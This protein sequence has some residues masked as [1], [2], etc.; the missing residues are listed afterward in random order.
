[1]VNQDKGQPIGARNDQLTVLTNALEVILQLVNTMQT[2]SDYTNNNMRHHIDPA[3]SNHSGELSQHCTSIS[4]STP[5]PSLLQQSTRIAHRVAYKDLQ[6]I[7]PPK[8]DLLESDVS[9]IEDW[10]DSSEGEGV[11]EAANMLDELCQQPAVNEQTT[12]NISTPN[13]STQIIE[14]TCNPTLV[15]GNVGIKVVLPRVQ[16]PSPTRVSKIHTEPTPDSTKH[17]STHKAAKEK[18]L[19][20]TTLRNIE[21]AVVQGQCKICDLQANELRRTKLHARQ[22][23]TLHMCKCKLFSP[24]RDTI[25]RHQRQG[26]CPLQQ[27]DIY[28]VDKESYPAFCQHIGW[29]DPPKFG[30]CVPAKQG[31]KRVS[32]PTPTRTTPSSTPI[33]IYTVRAGYKIPKKTPPTS[34]E[35]GEVTSSEDDTPPPVVASKICRPKRARSESPATELRK[36]IELMEE[37]E[38]LEQRARALREE[39]RTIRQKYDKSKRF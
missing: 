1:M 17:K 38:E 23:F 22:H 25:Y 4:K 3:T 12:P 2:Q 9:D 6:K 32:K 33:G 16:A 5:D 37:A 7:M 15:A 21:A 8:P 10:D 26:R 20:S 35:E 11:D 13:I 14:P 34:I 18:W 31:P 36:A 24:S 27:D 28:E 39:A 19:S 29:T 30:R